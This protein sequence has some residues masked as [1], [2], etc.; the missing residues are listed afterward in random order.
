MIEPAT[1]KRP[2]RGK[3]PSWRSLKEYLRLT[4]KKTGSV[5]F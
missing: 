2:P 4:K 1:I 3:K 5:Y